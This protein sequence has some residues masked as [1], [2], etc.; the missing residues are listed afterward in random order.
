MDVSFSCVCP[1]IDNEF[2]HNIVKVAKMPQLDLLVIFRQVSKR[3]VFCPP[4]IQV[5][6]QSDR[7]HVERGF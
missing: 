7:R 2:R 5:H 6:L 3:N 4:R 1:I